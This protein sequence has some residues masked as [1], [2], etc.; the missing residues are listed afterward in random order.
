MGREPAN[1]ALNFSFHCRVFF[2]LRGRAQLRTFPRALTICFDN[3]EFFTLF[4]QFSWVA[5]VG[6]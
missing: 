3:S 6:A 2:A 5:Y 4:T 1:S